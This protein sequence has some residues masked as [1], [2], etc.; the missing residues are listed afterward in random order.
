VTL[1]VS[2]NVIDLYRRH[3]AEWDAARRS[4]GWND[5]VWIEMFA[6][7]L[8]KGS[9]VLDLGCGGG[10][11]VARFLVDEG[12]RVTGV[13]SSPA[14]IA[15]AA[16][17]MPDQ[18]WIVADMRGLELGRRFDAVLAWDSY[19]HLAHD[20]QRSMF[21]I[22]DAHAA[23]DAVLMFNTGAEHGEAIS[24]STFKGEA[25]YHASLAPEEYRSLLDR[26]GFDIIDHVAND[27]RS[28]GRTAWL[29][30]RKQAR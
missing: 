30:E 8:A 3:A 19:F 7:R 28:G 25:L 16:R 18:E 1:S 11:P 15:L 10:E 2:E 27:A 4:S 6:M 21:A 14:M 17:R 12:L 20:A 24:T 5:R 29:C 22:F 26:S 13:D 23:D 9:R